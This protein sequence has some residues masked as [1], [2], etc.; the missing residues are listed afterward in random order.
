MRCLLASYVKYE[1]RKRRAI[2]LL[3]DARGRADQAIAHIGWYGRNPAD[4]KPMVQAAHAALRRASRVIQWLG[5]N[6]PE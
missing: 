4:A 1:I 3:H 6:E 2:E 5:K